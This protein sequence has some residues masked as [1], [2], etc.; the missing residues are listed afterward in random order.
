MEKFMQYINIS[1]LKKLSKKERKNNPS[2]KNHADSLDVIAKKHQYDSWPDLLDSSRIV[3][4]DNELDEESFNNKKILFKGRDG[5]IYNF[6]NHSDGSNTYFH[7]EMTRLSFIDYESEKETDVQIIINAIESFNKEIKYFYELL[8]TDDHEK[9]YSYISRRFLPDSYNYSD[10]YSIWPDKAKILCRVISYVFVN[11]KMDKTF[12]NLRSLLILKNL[13]N[14]I[15]DNDLQSNHRII[16]FLETI[17]YQRKLDK[18][19]KFD[20]NDSVLEQ[21]GFLAM[22]L[23]ESLGVWDTSFK[24]FSPKNPNVNTIK[25]MLSKDNETMFSLGFAKKYIGSKSLAIHKYNLMLEKK[26]EIDDNVL[27]EVLEYFIKTT[28][29]NSNI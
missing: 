2:I 14:A 25:N 1:E 9:L 10:D 7:D 19:K 4:K 18:D 28:T 12:K 27:Q 15:V 29:N 13:L 17:H 8:K 24:T 6:R 22:Q 16:D 11:S 21:V 20:L 3:I 26:R 23:T 5:R